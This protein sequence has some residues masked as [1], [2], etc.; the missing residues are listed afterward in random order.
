MHLHLCTKR[1]IIFNQ[2]PNLLFDHSQVE[3]MDVTK[4]HPSLIFG[5]TYFPLGMKMERRW[6]ELSLPQFFS[7]FLTEAETNTE[8]PEMNTETNTPENRKGANTERTWKQ[9]WALTKN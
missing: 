9:K 8:T 3:T 6:K 7:Y 2:P 5:P 1:V 4:T